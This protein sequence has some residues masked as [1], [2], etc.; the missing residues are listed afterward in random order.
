MIAIN[1]HISNRNL[2]VLIKDRFIPASFDVITELFLF[3]TGTAINKREKMM[4]NLAYL[5]SGLT[6]TYLS[7]QRK[8]E[9]QK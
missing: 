1:K 9:R 4:R 3:K 8:K 2:H 6:E 7:P 5:G